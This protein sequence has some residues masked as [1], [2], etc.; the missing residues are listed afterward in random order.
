MGPVTTSYSGTQQ[1][2]YVIAHVGIV[3]ARSTR[4]RARADETEVSSI[5]PSRSGSQRRASST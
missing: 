5:W 3:V 4:L 2:A 1:P